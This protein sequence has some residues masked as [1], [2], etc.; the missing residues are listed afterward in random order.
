M[1][2]KLL[3]VAFSAAMLHRQVDGAEIVI[4]GFD[5]DAS[6]TIINETLWQD[7]IGD[8]DAVRS[9]RITDR[10]GRHASRYDRGEYRSAL[11]PC[12]DTFARSTT[13]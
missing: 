4:D 5:D 11:G 7:G 13:F 12:F 1:T 2:Y 9:L 8:L 10:R 6:V 3:L